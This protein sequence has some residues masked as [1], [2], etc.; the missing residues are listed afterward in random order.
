M[1]MKH[2]KLYSVAIYLVDQV[3]GGPE[4]GGW[5]YTVG[6]LCKD[7]EFAKYLRGFDD[8]EAAFDYAYSINHDDEYIISLNANR[9]STHSVLSEGEFAAIVVEGYPA[10]FPAERPHYE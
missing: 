4:E 6:Q 2:K 1:I 8:Q 3:Y 5:Y 10:D 9:P 7:P